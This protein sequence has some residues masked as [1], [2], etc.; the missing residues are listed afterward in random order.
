MERLTRAN[1]DKHLKAIVWTS[2]L[3]ARSN[4]R[5]FL[6][7]S[8]YIIQVWDGNRQLVRDLLQENYQLIMSNIESSYLDQGAGTFEYI[9]MP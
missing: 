9:C 5:K 6:N 8:S 3:T 4:G 1:N 2:G 7:S